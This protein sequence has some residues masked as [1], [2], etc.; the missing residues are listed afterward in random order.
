K[1]KFFDMQSI[2][3]GANRPADAPAFEGTVIGVVGAGMMGAAIAFVAAQAGY[4]VVLRDVS[5][6]NAERGKQYAQTQ[7]DR[8]VER[9][10]TTADNRDRV[11]ERITA[12]ADLADLAA[13]D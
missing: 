13:A 7:L 5:L 6:E 2:A 3:K 10:S 8:A 11:L 12:T 9:G 1:S 4:T